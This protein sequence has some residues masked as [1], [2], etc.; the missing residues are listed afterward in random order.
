MSVQIGQPV[1]NVGDRVKILKTKGS[2]KWV[3]C[4]ALVIE[5]ADGGQT[6]HAEVEGQS[7]LRLIFDPNWLELLPLEESKDSIPSLE[8]QPITAKPQQNTLSSQ[9]S[10]LSEEPYEF[11]KCTITV[12]IQF[13]PDDGYCDRQVLFG[14]RNH[15]DP[16]ILKLM[17][18]SELGE[19]P[20]VI[21]ELLASLELDLPNRQAASLKR[22]AE[23]Q[24][25]KDKHPAVTPKPDNQSTGSKQINGSKPKPVD[26]NT[27]AQ[28]SLF[29]LF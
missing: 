24:L 22:H 10:A 3:G 15:A 21:A 7:G 17:R 26:S 19:L 29:E 23:E 28:M 6:I 14:V 25:A 18:Q 5:V 9:Q 12:G 4:T 16:P 1:V 2:K 11:S 20:P 8:Q 13:L 27:P